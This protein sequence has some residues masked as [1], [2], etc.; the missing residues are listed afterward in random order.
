MFKVV[1]MNVFWDAIQ[2]FH[3]SYKTVMIGNCFK[4]IKRPSMSTGNFWTDCGQS[5][6]GW[7]LLTEIRYRTF[8][9]SVVKT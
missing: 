3:L 7:C 2:D 1:Q 6:A 9:K 4:T 5:L 8:K